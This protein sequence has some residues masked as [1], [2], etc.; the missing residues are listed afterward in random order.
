M[1]RSIAR[2]TDRDLGLDATGSGGM[3]KIIEDRRVLVG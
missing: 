3:V 1:R 2:A